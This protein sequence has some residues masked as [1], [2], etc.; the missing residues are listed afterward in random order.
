MGR[1]GEVKGERRRITTHSVYQI[2]MNNFS[3]LIVL[4]TMVGFSHPISY[5]R[6][7]HKTGLSQ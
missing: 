7:T 3:L 2:Q 5:P 1:E 6:S 4:T